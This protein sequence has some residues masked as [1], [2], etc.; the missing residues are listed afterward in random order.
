MEQSGL[1]L[2]TTQPWI[3]ELPRC[4]EG[5]SFSRAQMSLPLVPEGSVKLTTS[6]QSSSASFCFVL[7]LIFLFGG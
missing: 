3:W 5:P 7:R 6:F 4:G 1:P 2:S